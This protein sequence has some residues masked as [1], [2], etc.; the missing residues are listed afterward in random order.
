MPSND[1]HNN[2]AE[3]CN[4]LECILQNRWTILSFIQETTLPTSNENLI[5]ILETPNISDTILL[6]LFE[7]LSFAKLKHNTTT[8]EGIRVL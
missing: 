5:R 3:F 4:I 7:R 6:D 2:K 1:N 8:K